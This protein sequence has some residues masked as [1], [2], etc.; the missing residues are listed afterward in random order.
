MLPVYIGIY[1]FMLAIVW[2]FFLIA[3]QHSYKFKHFSTNIVPVTNVLMIALI[4][5]SILGFIMIF[6]LWWDS[7]KTLE[8]N[9][10]EKSTQNYY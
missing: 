4:I 10:S 5:L 8:I 3:K 9:S 1:I 6:S 7:T 2:G